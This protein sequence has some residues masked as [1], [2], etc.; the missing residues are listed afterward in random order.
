LNST[1]GVVYLPFPSIEAPSIRPART[2]E[3]FNELP[4]SRAGA[5]R[6]V[7]QFTLVHKQTGK[8]AMQTLRD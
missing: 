7:C 8:M 5:L 2:G 6:S 3:F 4:T 1:N